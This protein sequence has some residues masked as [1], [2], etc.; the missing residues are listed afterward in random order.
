[1]DVQVGDILK[2]KKKHPCGEF[3]FD[4]LRVGMDFKIRCRN[5]KREV[6]VPRSKIEKSIKEIIRSTEKEK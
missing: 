4:V 5:C 6:M 3:C 2:M 1:M